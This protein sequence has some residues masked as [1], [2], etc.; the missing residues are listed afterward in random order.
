M[1]VIAATARRTRTPG[2]LIWLTFPDAR[3]DE[4]LAAV[5]AAH[6]RLVLLVGGPGWAGPV[7]PAVACRSLGDAV[8]RLERS[9][10]DRP[11]AVGPRPASHDTTAVE[12]AQV[13]K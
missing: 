8:A 4:G 12:V 3:A 2:V 6:R 7:A 10:S 9:W 5:R 11:A 1:S 13:A